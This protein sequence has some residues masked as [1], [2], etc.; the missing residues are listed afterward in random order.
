MQ[1]KIKQIIEETSSSMGISMTHAR[2]MYEAPFRRIRDKIQQ[3]PEI[4]IDLTEDDFDYFVLKHFGT[5]RLSLKRLEN[6]KRNLITKSD[7]ESKE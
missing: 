1:K 6:L 2:L 7:G 5:F 3:Q 4:T